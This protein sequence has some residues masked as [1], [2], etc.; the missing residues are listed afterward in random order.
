MSSSDPTSAV[1]STNARLERLFRTIKT[2]RLQ[3]PVPVP[4]SSIRGPL[5]TSSFLVDSA[6]DN[7]HFSSLTNI[8]S[9][10]NSDTQDDF[11]IVVNSAV[12]LGV[13]R[14]LLARK[15]R[16]SS[17]LVH[18]LCSC[19]TCVTNED[20]NK[21]YSLVVL[22]A[23]MTSTGTVPKAFLQY[24]QSRENEV[25][26]SEREKSQR[27]NGGIGTELRGAG[28]AI[29]CAAMKSTKTGT[30]V[31][32]AVVSPTVSANRLGIDHHQQVTSMAGV[33]YRNR[34]GTDPNTRKG[35]YHTVRFS[36][37]VVTSSQEHVQSQN[38][39]VEGH[40]P[41]VVA[42]ATGSPDLKFD[43][44]SKMSDRPGLHLS[45]DLEIDT[46]VG[47]PVGGQ[48]GAGL[49]P[50][51]IVDMDS[52]D[53]SWIETTE[54]VHRRPDRVSDSPT[55]TFA[56]TIPSSETS[57]RTARNPNS[58]WEGLSQAYRKRQKH[59]QNNQIFAQEQQQQEQDNRDR[60]GDDPQSQ[61]RWR[62]FSVCLGRRLRRASAWV[63]SIFRRK[64]ESSCN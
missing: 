25:Q 30:I 38:G 11:P 49:R 51:R 29:C 54:D 23:Q 61:K 21:H 32:N 7:L 47:D 20:V 53:L 37:P 52:D 56:S 35:N 60:Q 41:S 27:V 16:R 24:V 40:E 10:N 4:F 62:T 22:A 58:I 55:G 46:A 15:Q 28:S 34:H 3:P 13:H 59:R 18:V 14:L 44:D 45:P 48:G 63:P 31:S 42:N 57:T 12:I 19:G 43:P 8:R 39:P 9:A 17:L 26:A 64:G 36:C 6:D 1:P 50:R 2:A 5:Q 33:A